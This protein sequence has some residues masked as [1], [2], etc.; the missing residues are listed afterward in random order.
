[1]ASPFFLH[2]GENPSLVLVSFLLNGGNY[3]KWQRSMKMA[4]LSKNKYKFVDGSIQAYARDDPMFEVW[5][6]CN[7]MVMSWIYRSETPTIAESISC[8]DNALDI[9]NDLRDRFSQGDSYRIGDIHE[10]IYSLQ[11]NTSSV[12]E[13]Y[14]HLKILWD[15]MVSLRP[16][17]MCICNPKCCCAVLN[18]LKTNLSNDQVIRFLKGLNESFSHVRSQILMS[19]PLPPINKVCSLVIQHERQFSAPKHSTGDISAFAAARSYLYNSQEAEYET[20]ENSNFSGYEG[21]CYPGYE[22]NINYVRGRGTS[23]YRGSYNKPGF[24]FPPNKGKLCSF[25]GL[26]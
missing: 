17:P 9:L 22:G 25:C 6:R 5:E 16:F 14:T 20:T 12:I 1:M 3:H 26:S 21:N 7:T 23:T 11:Q 2:P 13:Y 24:A 15:E 4:L 18:T 19:E 10:E 8:L